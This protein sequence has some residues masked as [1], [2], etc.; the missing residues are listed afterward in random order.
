M[1]IIKSGWI[2]EAILNNNKA[3]YFFY[4]MGIEKKGGTFI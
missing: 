4:E 2:M 1:K 3:K